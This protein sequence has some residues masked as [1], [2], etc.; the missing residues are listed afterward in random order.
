MGLFEGNDVLTRPFRVASAPVAQATFGTIASGG[1][2]TAAADATRVDGVILEDY[3]VSG[4]SL[5]YP[6]PNRTGVAVRLKGTAYVEATEILAEGDEVSVAAAGK[7]KK[8]NATPAVG[9]V[10]KGGAV[11][12]FVEVLIYG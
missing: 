9:K 7:A 5:P 6:Y 10:L 11:G 12:E 4:L 2:A 8:V 1:I 3:A